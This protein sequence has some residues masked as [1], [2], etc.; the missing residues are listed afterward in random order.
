[1][2]AGGVFALVAVGRAVALARRPA[3]LLAAGTA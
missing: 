2:L 3:P 1:V